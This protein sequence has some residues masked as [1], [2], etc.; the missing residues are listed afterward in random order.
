MFENIREDWQTYE[1]D[2][3][4]Q[5]FWVMLV[6]RFGRWRY[7]IENRALRWPFSF[8]YKLLKVLSQIMTGIDLPCEVQL[9][10]RFLIEHFGGI[11]I[12]GDAVFGDDCVVRNGVTVGLR[13]RG[14]RGAPVIGDRVDIGAGAKVL[15]PIR[16]GKD[17]AIGANAVVI[18]DVPDG[19]LAVGVP[20]RIISRGDATSIR[21]SSGAAISSGK[22]SRSEAGATTS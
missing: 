1:R 2:W 18:Q 4:R 16:I 21:A 10:R 3:A 15:G 12:S 9:G 5:G 19:C 13:H 11:I 6:Y 17:V 7:R 14:V 22:D 8:L 20:A